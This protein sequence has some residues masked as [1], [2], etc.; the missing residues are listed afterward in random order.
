MRFENRLNKNSLDVVMIPSVRETK[1]KIQKFLKSYDKLRELGVKVTQNSTP[2]NNEA[3]LKE[4]NTAAQG[5][6]RHG[7]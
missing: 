6:V 7:V 2:A 3:L 4:V 1:V 5:R